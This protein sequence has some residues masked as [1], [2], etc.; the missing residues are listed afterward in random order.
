MK[1]I[2][3]S[4]AI[5]MSAASAAYADPI[6]VMTP[7]ASATAADKAAYVAQL[8]TAV[9]EVCED[10]AKP[11]IG[12]NYFIYQSCVKQTRLEVA[13]KDPTGL[14]AARESAGGAIIAA[15]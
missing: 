6:T 7:K 8:D 14:Y 10:A 11:L 9:K 12:L 3:I 1:R 4:A 5:A 13:Q 2:V 15:K